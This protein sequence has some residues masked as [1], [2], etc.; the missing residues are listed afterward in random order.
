ML[1]GQS[2]NDQIVIH[3]VSSD[4]A[5]GNEV[6]SFANCD[7]DENSCVAAMIEISDEECEARVRPQAPKVTDTD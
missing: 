1:T 3:A 4:P 6:L 5:F 2:Q 7:E